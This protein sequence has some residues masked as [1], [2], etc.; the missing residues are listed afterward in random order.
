MDYGGVILVLHATFNF[1]PNARLLQRLRI[2][3]QANRK[4][5]NLLKEEERSIKNYSYSHT[6]ELSF[7]ANED[8]VENNTTT[9]GVFSAILSG[10]N[11]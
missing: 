8:A 1:D 4:V 3:P 10:P 7:E 11:P 5:G 6:F 2:L 9:E